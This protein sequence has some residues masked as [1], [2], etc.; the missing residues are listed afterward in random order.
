MDIEEK[1]AFNLN[2]SFY[3]SAAAEGHIQLKPQQ[4]LIRARSDI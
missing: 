3:C 1:K 4:N 2:S